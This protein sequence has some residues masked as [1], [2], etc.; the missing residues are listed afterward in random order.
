MFTYFIYRHKLPAG[1][2]GYTGR[3]SRRERAADRI[4]TIISSLEG[5]IAMLQEPGVDVCLFE[6][7]I[8]QVKGWYKASR[9][10]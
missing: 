2:K 8:C 1:K 7:H 3:Y 6:Y 10:L 9:S 4:M 5:E